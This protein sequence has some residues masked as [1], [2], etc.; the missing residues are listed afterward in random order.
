MITSNQV[1]AAR[2][3]INWSQDYLAEVT[4]LAS[5]TIRNLESGDMSPRGGTMNTIRQVLEDA[6]V[7]FTC[8]G[9]IRPSNRQVK[10]YQGV[11]SYETFFTD[12]LN[13]IKESGSDLYCVF[14]SLHAM[15]QIC[16]MKN[17]RLGRM[18]LISKHAK[19]K[20]LTSEPLEPALLTPSFEF[21]TI[22]KQ[23]IGAATYFIYG[24]KHVNIIDEPDLSGL[25]VVYKSTS[26]VRDY[27]K[28]FLALW[29]MA[30]P[31]Y[32]EATKEERCVPT[33][34]CA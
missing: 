29:D 10:I 22:L 5:S 25:I 34:N 12:M 20:C 19:I 6:G 33:R 9:G 2:A 15:M 18:D 23:H 32:V 1:R 31:V 17:S 11:D 24:N 8:D 28:H 14:K 7:E 3:L 4:G 16:A 30:P 13:D 27:R 26:A 21:R